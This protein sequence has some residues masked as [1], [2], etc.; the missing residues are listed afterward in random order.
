MPQSRHQ[1]IEGVES[2]AEMLVGLADQQAGLTLVLDD[3]TLP[4]PTSLVRIDRDRRRCLFTASLLKDLDALLAEG[5][6]FSL[7]ASEPTMLITSAPMP[8]LSYRRRGGRF[9]IETELPAF[10][11]LSRQRNAF[12]ATLERGMQVQVVLSHGVDTPGLEGELLDLSIGGLLVSLP[13]HEA[14]HLT[15]DSRLERVHL[16]FPNG[17]SFHASG[18]VRH[19]RVSDEQESAL[20]GVAFDIDRAD[21]ERQAWFYVREIERE[22]VRLDPRNDRHVVPSRLFEVGGRVAVEPPRVESRGDA[23]EASSILE[24]TLAISRALSVQLINLQSGLALENDLLLSQ[25]QRLLALLREDRQGLFHALA[26][27]DQRT[28]PLVSHGLSVAAH[29]ADLESDRRSDE[30]LQQLIVCAMVHDFGKILLADELRLYQGSMNA[31]QLRQLHAHVE[32]LRFRFDREGIEPA[33]RRDVM[34][35]INERLDGSGYPRGLTR[36]ELSPLARLAAVVDAIDA[37]QRPR[38]D[39][40]AWLPLDAYRYIF[41]AGDCFDTTCVNR[42]VKRF[43]FTPIGSMVS[44]SRGFLGWVMRLD[45]RGR[46]WRVRIVHNRVRGQ[47][48]DVVLQGSDL[49]QLGTLEGCVERGSFH[50]R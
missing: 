39:R 8:L 38:S 37:M 13:P 12:R 14:T 46:P 20:V 27:V 43:G 23:R 49:E 44:W 42:Y 18:E 6:S 22:A 48:M 26:C 15:I 33:I 50:P 35:S 47:D 31:G 40:P 11:H 36:T 5:V 9:E 28:S 29:L 16:V 4:F 19:L 34:L 25:A 2:V 21:F 7:K 10:L 3:R 41:N 1:E 32:L 30:Q 17:E 24:T 45:S